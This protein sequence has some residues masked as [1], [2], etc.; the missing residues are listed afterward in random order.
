MAWYMG[1]TVADVSFNLRRREIGLLSTKGFS[2]SQIQRIFL[3]ETLMLGL[4]GGLLGVLFGFMLNPIFTQFSTE[5]LFDPKL[6]SPYTIVA[7]TVFGAVI[8]FLSTY[9]SARK[10]SRL[11]TVYALRE[12]LPANGMR[13]RRRRLPLL[14]F[15]LGA[16]KLIIF[17]LGINVTTEL[18]GVAMAGQN[19]AL[20]ILIGLVVVVDLVLNY[21]GPLL[22]FWGATKLFIEGSLKFQEL[23]TKFAKFLGDLGALATK[24]VRR[25]PARSAAIAF[26]IALIISYG[27]Q[28][29]AQL[30]SE[31]DYVTRNVY[32]Q[33]GADVSV[34]VTTPGEASN[35]SS[36]IL[37]NVSSS[38]ESPTIEYRFTGMTLDGRIGI[39]LKV[40]QPE[41]WLK[42]AYYEND[43]FTGNSPETSF[44]SLA[45]DM[46]TVILEKNLA[47]LLALKVGDN[48]T[49]FLGGGGARRLVVVG[50]F[51]QET[52]SQ[53][54][55]VS[56]Y[57]SFIPDQLYEQIR[58]L[59]V[60]YDTRILLKLRPGENG[61]QVAA[62]IRSL[63]LNVSS[64][65]S[66]ADAYEFYQSDVVTVGSLDAQRLGVVFVVLAASVGTALVS[67]VSMKERSREA[68]IMSVKGL[69]YKQLAI[70]F[71]TENF[72]VVT[73]AVVLGIVVGFIVAYG[74]IASSNSFM[75]VASVISRRF[76]FPADAVITLTSCVALIF[77]SAILPIVIM[78]RSYVT[79]LERMVRLR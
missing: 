66:F 6:I 2:R 27:T 44:E 75:P 33:V 5:L 76:V 28:V 29:T 25:N 1:T 26:L 50:F 47:N 17:T 52:S 10:A 78:A 8:A 70:M 9:S 11:S 16:Y 56:Q 64:V 77:A 21:I 63:G 68:T 65:N 31:R 41:S 15:T 49:L 74:N 19:F 36:M 79:R 58:D 59:V 40:V 20:A 55:T 72:A 23:T 39:I 69:S 46:N 7:T 3:T 60:V 30:A 32:S 45:A 38:I 22:F 24:N 34:Y 14:A 57:W 54:G 67:V 12:Y 51:G 35:I 4:L 42:T 71:L 61:A 73:F 43:L 48:V 18:T 53:Q 62:S 13:L 37:A